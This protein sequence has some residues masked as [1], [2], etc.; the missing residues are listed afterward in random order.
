RLFYEPVKDYKPGKH[1]HVV[2]RFDKGPLLVFNDARRF[3]VLDYISP[4]E[5]THKLLGHLGIDPLSDDL[6]PEFLFDAVKKRKT[7]F[8]AI[9]MDQKMINGLGNIYVCEALFR[10]KINPKR[11]GTSITR[12]EAKKLVAAIK[13]V[14]KEAIDSGGSSLRDYIQPD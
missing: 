9:L 10:A 11:L 14:L 1:D 3:G 7:T 12:D 4:K 2:F 6:T 5:K 8:K 13:A